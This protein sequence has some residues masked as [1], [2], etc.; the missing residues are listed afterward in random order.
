M[1]LTEAIAILVDRIGWEDDDT[2]EGVSLSASNLLSNS[3]RV[4]QD[5]HS[6]VTLNNIHET[7]PNSDITNGEFNTYLDKLKKRACRKV[8]VDAMEKDNIDEGVL[9]M[10]PFLYDNA[11]SMQMVIIVSELI[12]SSTRLNAIER[13]TDTFIRKLNYDIFRESTNATKSAS[14]YSLGIA[15]RYGMEIRSLQRRFGQHKVLL[16]V[17]TNGERIP[18]WSEQINSDL[19]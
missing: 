19:E 7:Q 15:T 2:L 11:I 3:G 17:Q 6:A 12:I 14:K 8:L 13:I 9:T 10:Y 18:N 1:N 5:E 16:K 4:F